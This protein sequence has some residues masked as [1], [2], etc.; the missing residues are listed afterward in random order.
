MKQIEDLSI[1]TT[2]GKDMRVAYDDDVSWPLNWYLRDYKQ[3][4]FFGANPT[5]DLLEYPVILVGD[6]NWTAVEPLLADRFNRYE[7]I[8]MWW[9]NQDYWNLKRSAIEAE[10][11]FEA[12]PTEA[13]RSP[14]GF[15]EYL[16]RAW[17]HIKPFFTDSQL[18]VAIW[19]IWIDRD[20][21]RYADWTGRDMSLPRWSPSDRM[22]LYIRKDIAAM[23]W[24]YGITSASI[25]PPVIEDPYEDK[26]VDLSADLVIGNEGLSP[27]EFFR[28]R[29]LAIAPDGTIY[30]VDTANHRVQHL[31]QSGEVLNVWGSYAD[32]SAGNAPGGTFNEPWGIAVSEQGTVYVAD[33]WNHRIQWFSAEGDFLGMLG[34]E[35]LGEEADAFWGPRDVVVDS[36]GRVYVSDTGNKRIKVFDQAGNFIVQF[37]SAGYLPGFLDEPVGLAVDDFD[38][39]YIADTWNQ[40]VQV[41]DDPVDQYEPVYE[42]TLDSWFGQSLE[43]KPYLGI[44]ERGVLCTTDP[45]GFRILCFNLAGEFL[46]GWGGA[47]GLE[48]NQFNILSG[49]DIADSGAVWVVDSGNH[50]IMRFQP[51][52]SIDS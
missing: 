21:R 28:P 3:Q 9:P 19:D 30:V 39:I 33:T 52:I 26:L 17:G 10:R 6:N 34:R 32:I 35:G 7:Y 51:D 11:N 5:R 18:R 29:D 31:S 12:P 2:D 24:D 36:D 46:I 47:F 23:V 22:R 50:R 49:I 42:W 4:Y 25:N 20:F 40:R 1:R 41:F 45:E 14:M 13:E 37:G 48:A 8:R 27:G 44:D 38:R 16:I 43:N 15:S